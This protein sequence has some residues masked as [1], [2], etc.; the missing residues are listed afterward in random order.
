VH[1]RISL[2]GEIIPLISL[3]TFTYHWANLLLVVVGYISY[4]QKKKKEPEVAGL[5]PASQEQWDN[6]LVEARGVSD[7]FSL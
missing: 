7:I 6:T 2:G 4:H 1:T 5:W 3:Q